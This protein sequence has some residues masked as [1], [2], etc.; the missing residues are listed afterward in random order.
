M[1]VSFNKLFDSTFL[2]FVRIFLAFNFCFSFFYLFWWI[3]GIQFTSL[4]GFLLLIYYFFLGQLFSV[5]VFLNCYFLI[6]GIFLPYLVIWISHASWFLNLRDEFLPLQKRVHFS[7]FLL[8]T[9][10][11]LALL[12]VVSLSFFLPLPSAS[13]SSSLPLGSEENTTSST[14]SQTTALVLYFLSIS[15]YLLWMIPLFLY[16]WF[17]QAREHNWGDRKKVFVSVSFIGF[18]IVPFFLLELFQFPQVPDFLLSQNVLQWDEVTQTWFVPI[19]NHITF[20]HIFWGIPLWLSAWH[21]NWEIRTPQ[22]LIKGKKL[23]IFQSIWFIWLL[24]LTFFLVGLLSSNFMEFL[25]TV[26]RFL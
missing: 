22:N 19:M 23:S 10:G 14:P 3:Q 7:I 20:L 21:F 13:P 6:F 12:F 26:L 25:V 15:K 11:V 9:L 4:F 18:A 5:L 8:L 2:R 24:F 16:L 17:L 1:N